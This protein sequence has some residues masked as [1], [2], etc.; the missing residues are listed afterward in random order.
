M[1]RA[2]GSKAGI[3]RVLGMLEVQ[4]QTHM[5]A[6]D[7]VLYPAI[8]DHPASAASLEPL[9][10]DH[11]ELRQMLA[12]LQATLREEPTAEQDEQIAVQIHDLADLLGC[13]SA[14]KRPWCSVAA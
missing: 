3:G 1:R 7:Q 2:H 10:D 4:F 6:E 11:A 12:R 5:A 14:R 13:T 9:H 8:A